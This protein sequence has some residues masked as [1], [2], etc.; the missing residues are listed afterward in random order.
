MTTTMQRR[1][2]TSIFGLLA[3]TVAA[4]LLQSLGMHPASALVAGGLLGAGCA[5]ALWGVTTP[6]ASAPE[7]LRWLLWPQIAAVI[8]I[9]WL[10]YLHLIPHFVVMVPGSDKV[11]HFLLFGAVTFFA[12][13]W[14]RDRRIVGIPMSI[15]LPATLACIEEGLQHFS[16]HRTMDIGDLI[17]DLS[18]MTVAFLLARALYRRG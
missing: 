9:T 8:T 6:D 11:M 4:M 15:A 12:E 1:Q 13:L 16:P 10:A 18:G 3:L 5:A 17:C 14:L 7:R 2:L